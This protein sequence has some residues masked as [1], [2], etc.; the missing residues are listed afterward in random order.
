[1]D[2]ITSPLILEVEIE[3]TLNS[4]VCALP[5]KSHLMW[6]LLWLILCS[7]LWH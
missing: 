3:A 6:T 1:M 2:N 4:L 7:L 5:L